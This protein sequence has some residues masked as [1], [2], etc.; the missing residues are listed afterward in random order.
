[1]KADSHV[2]FFC[3]VSI[4]YLWRMNKEAFFGSVRTSLFGGKL[5]QGVV[6]TLESI[7]ATCDKYCITDYRQRAYILATARHESYSLDRNPE[8]LPVREGWAKTNAGAIAAVTALYK[9]GGISKNY[10]LP[11]ANG[12]SYYGRGFVQITHGGNYKSVG[13][14]LGIALYNNPDLALNRSTASEILV[15]GMK[16]GI[17][18]GRKLSQY[19]TEK[20][21]ENVE[22]RRII[23]GKD[24][25]ER[26]AS[27][28]EKFYI[29]LILK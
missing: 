12:K 10:A 13:K 1:L 8:W 16:E 7:L 24:Q 2:G 17:F 6:D 5:T 19:F 28:A 22:A 26:I 20:D 15:V 18:T 29:A 25:A 3:L 23:N 4:R 21:T 11:E 27:L 9:S 14:R